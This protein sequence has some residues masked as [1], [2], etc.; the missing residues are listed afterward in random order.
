MTFRLLPLICAIAS[1]SAVSS[2]NKPKTVDGSSE[3]AMKT[4]IEKMRE[5]LPNEEKEQLVKD[6]MAISLEGVNLFEVGQNPD[7]MKMQMRDRLNGKS[8][9]EINRAADEV[10]KKFEI[11]AEERRRKQEEE[12]KK[13]EAEMAEQRAKM[14]IQVES[15]IQELVKAQKKAAEDT[16]ALKKFDVQRSRFYYAENRFSNDPTIELT[17]KNGTG[18]AI[19]RVSFAGTLSSPGRAVPWVKE[20]FSYKIPGGLEP[21]EE[22]T[23]KLQPNQF[24]EWRN[25]PKDGTDTVLTITTL[26]VEGANGAVLLDSEFPDHKANRL[27]RLRE[28]LGEMKNR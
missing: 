28:S 26:S 16:E 19:S 11:E 13:A 6:M 17:V 21:G 14:V 12:E 7:F 18:A 15:E 4:S 22:V 3:E 23:W 24:G 20:N 1:L 10:R 27:A 9:E 2:C 25:A 8:K 5:D